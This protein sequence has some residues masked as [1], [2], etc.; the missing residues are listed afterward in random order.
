MRVLVWLSWWVDSSVTAHLLQQQGHEV[1]GWFMKNYAEPENPHC[2][3]RQDRDMAIRVAHH[4]G[5]DTFVIFDFRTQYYERII[6]YIYKGYE[7]WRTPNPDV[8]CNSLIKFDLFLQKAKELWCDAIATWHYAV[9]SK[10]LQ[11]PSSTTTIYSLSKW[12]DTT[13]D[14]SYFLS[15]LSQYQ[16][17]HTLLPLGA[18]TK[19]EVRQI[20]HDLWLPNADRKDSQWLCFIG[21]VP[22]KEF[23]SKALPKKQGEIVSTDWTV[24]WHHDWAHFVTIGQRTWLWLSGWPRYVVS[25]DTT[26][27][28]ITVS[29]DQQNDLSHTTLIARGRHWIDPRSVPTNPF[30]A[31]AKIRYRQDDQICQVIPQAYKTILI[32]FASPQRAISPWQ[33]VV[34]YTKEWVV[35][36]NG[37]I[38]SYA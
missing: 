18:R 33:I 20:A 3:T 38:D 27:N 14:Q 36:G 2:H 22:I 11:S 7:Q 35:L 13:K 29:K 32:N 12:K 6:S 30:E 19:S 1:V 34:L 24:V 23:L 26:T 21:N 9:I 25:K 8:L 10:T 17:S 28:T 37:H 4:L 5:I 15:W 31:Y 16:L